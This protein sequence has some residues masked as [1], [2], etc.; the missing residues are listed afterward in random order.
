[1]SCSSSLLFS[2]VSRVTNDKVDD[3]SEDVQNLTLNQSQL[4]REAVLQWISLLNFAPQ[5]SD[6]S[7]RRQEGT[8]LWLLESQEFQ[9][10]KGKEGETLVCQGMPG[11][12]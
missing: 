9:A 5:Q 1:M 10:W 4:E 3:I 7:S 12:G 8:G 11:A 2:R 6:L